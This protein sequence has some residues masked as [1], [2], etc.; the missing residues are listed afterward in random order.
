MDVDRRACSGGLELSLTQL[1][2]FGCEDA[3]VYTIAV[4]YNVWIGMRYQ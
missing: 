3:F 1:V 2:G 4:R